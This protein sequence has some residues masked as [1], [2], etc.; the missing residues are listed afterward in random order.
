[1]RAATL[2]QMSRRPLFDRYPRLRSRVPHRVLGPMWTPTRRLGRLSAHLGAEVWI[3]RDDLTA[4][5]YGGNKT[6]KLEYSLA[7]ALERDAR[8]VITHGYVGSNHCLATAVHGRRLGLD[9]T[10]LLIQLE[11]ELRGLEPRVGAN[12]AST[13]ATGADLVSVANRG[14]LRG[15]RARA[16]LR[17]AWKRGRVPMHIPAGASDARGILGYVNAGLELVDQILDARLP[18]PGRIYLPFGTAGSSVGLAIGLGLGGLSIPLVPV[19][20]LDPAVSNEVTFAR[21]FTQT[22]AWLRRYDRGIPQLVAPPLRLTRTQLGR[23]YGHPTAASEA[24]VR[25]AAQ[26]EGLVLEPTY[27]GKA[28]AALVEDMGARPPSSGPALFWHT[29]DGRGLVP[30]RGAV[31]SLPPSLRAYSSVVGRAS[32]ST[33]ST[34]SP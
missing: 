3:K 30:S 26:L 17:G 19:C 33:T 20:V 12:L 4:E 11:A 28:L 10:A 7:A 22:I 13:A 25:I 23:G 15:A 16:R 1:M 31:S 8:G 18:K 6:R 9:V 14:A 2:A 34:S 29:Y 5:P 32:A 21:L 27:G 24:A